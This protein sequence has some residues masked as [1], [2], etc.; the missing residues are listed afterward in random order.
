VAFVIPNSQRRGLSARATR[1]KKPQDAFTPGETHPMPKN[2]KFGAL[3]TNNVTGSPRQ[4][5]QYREATDPLTGLTYHV[6]APEA[7]GLPR[8]VFGLKRKLKGK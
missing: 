3:K 6:Y 8:E 1:K 7:G 4:G 5:S 2:L